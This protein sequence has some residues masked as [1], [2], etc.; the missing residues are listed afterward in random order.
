MGRLR[1]GFEQGMSEIYEEIHRALQAHYKRTSHGM[2]SSSEF[3]RLCAK[4]AIR[5][6][7]AASRGLQ[8]WLGLFEF[9]LEWLS[10]IHIA[11]DA[12]VKSDAKDSLPTNLVAY[13]LTGSGVSFGLALRSLCLSGF[14]TPARALLRS[15]VEAL[16]LC[17]ATTH[18]P[19]QRA[20]EDDEIKTFW[21]TAAS[22]KNLHRRIVKIEKT[23]GLDER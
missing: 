17:L 8:P 22:P 10:Y 4:Q 23:T 15:Y 12:G 1:P 18:D 11:L 2:P 9:G 7:K 3:R 20:Q 19:D 16:L 5:N 14:D 21:H 13:V 6:R